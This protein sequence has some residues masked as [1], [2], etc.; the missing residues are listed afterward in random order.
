MVRVLM[1]NTVLPNQYKWYTYLYSD[2]QS[3]D[4]PE[5]AKMYYNANNDQ[6][7]FIGVPKSWEGYLD[8]IIDNMREFHLHDEDDD[9]NEILEPRPDAMLFVYE[10]RPIPEGVELMQDEDKSITVQIGKDGRIGYS[11]IKGELTGDDMFE[12]IEML[13]MSFESM[14]INPQDVVTR[15]KKAIDYRLTPDEDEQSENQ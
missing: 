12:V 10:E 4:S 9:G 14:D 2:I 15:L 5:I 13:T 8:E 1:D 6:F 3:D 7:W 11:D